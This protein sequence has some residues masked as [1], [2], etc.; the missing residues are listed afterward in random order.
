MHNFNFPVESI[1]NANRAVILKHVESIINRKI[2]DHIW[3]NSDHPFLPHL[4]WLWGVL[5][6]KGSSLMI[7]QK[8]TFS[9][10]RTLHQMSRWCHGMIVTLRITLMRLSWASNVILQG[11]PNL[12]HHKGII[13]VTGTRCGSVRVHV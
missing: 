6:T 10:T 3:I 9:F 5:I 4:S 2:S 8:H 11:Y 12:W 7:V 1:G 13:I